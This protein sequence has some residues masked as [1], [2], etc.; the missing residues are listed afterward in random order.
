MDHMVA[1]KTSLMSNQGNYYN[2][3]MLFGYKNISATYHRLMDAV[4]SKQIWHNL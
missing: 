4:F 1:P 3:T 2:I